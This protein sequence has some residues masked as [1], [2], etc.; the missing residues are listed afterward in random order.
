MTRPLITT[1]LLFA[2]TGIANAQAAPLTL[3]RAVATALENN[4]RVLAADAS[5]EAARSSEREARGFRLPSVDLTQSFSSTDNPAEVFALT[6]NQGRFDMN[7]FFAADPNQPESLSTFITRLEVTQPI[8]T[9]GMIGTRNDQASLMAESA[10]LEARHTRERV[11]FDTATAFANA[12]KAAEHLDVMQRARD[13]TAAHVDL[14][15]KYAEQGLI[16]EAEVLNAEVHLARMEEMVAEAE[17]HVALTQAALNLHLGLSQS[18]RHTLAPLPPAPPVE[19]AAA[20]WIDAVSDQ[21]MDIQ[22]RQAELQAGRLEEKVARSSYWPEVG[23]KGTYDLYDDTLFGS[24]GHSGSIM[25]FARVNL[26]R[27]GSDAARTEKA[28][29]TARSGEA[30]VRMFS[31]A[32]QL[33]ARQAWELRLTAQRRQ[34]TAAAAVEAA[35]EAMRVREQRFAQGLDKMI[36]LLDAE[37]ALHESE[38]RELVARYDLILSTYQLYFASGTPLAALLSG[39]A[40][41]D[42]R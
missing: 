14:A 21:R 1:L 35:R 22:A 11:A 37:T 29:L 25:A 13:T 36:D 2:A 34:V 8:F 33:E 6:L 3:D 28:A 4:P 19:G 15:R 23:V 41:G 9:G 24:N 20:S 30:N 26:Y 31:E 7:E 40:E 42:A 39:A 12:T 10:S 32:A 16:V 27:G 38:L 5:A 17:A 18:T